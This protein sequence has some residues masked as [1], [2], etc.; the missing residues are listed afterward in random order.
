MSA[1]PRVA[2]HG[3]W[4][5]PISASALATG[6]VR[7]DQVRTC[8]GRIYW[9]EARPSEAGRCVVVCSDGDSTTDVTPPG[10]NA[11]SLVHEYGGG[12]YA[13]HESSVFFTN[14]EDQR[15]Y[16][17]DADTAPGNGQ[18]WGPPRP[19]T[20]EPPVAR[21]LRYA[22]FEPVP[23]GRGLYCV[24]EIHASA[25]E[26]VNE[27]VYLDLAGTREPRAV[28]GG[29]DFASFPRLNPA[30]DR[31]AW[32]TWDHPQMPFDGTDLWLGEVRADGSVDEV[33][34]VAGGPDESI[35]QPGFDP[36]GV[37]HFIS[38]RSGWWNLYS[39]DARGITPL[40]PMQAEFGRPQWALAMANYSFLPGGRIACVFGRDGTEH[41][42]VL[43]PG[44]ER[45]REIA[46]PF[47]SF[48]RIDS[49]SGSAIAITAASPEDSGG[50]VR[51][52]LDAGS[53]ELIRR[54]RSD[55]ID[56]AQVSRP[57]ALEFATTGG[58]VAHA[59]FY[60]PTNPAFRGPED[61]LPPLLVFSHGG[62][63]AA[64]SSALNFAVQYWTSRG[65]AVVDVNYRGSSGYGRAYR[66]SL[67]GQWGVADA[68]DC[69]AA[70]R[71]LASSG[72]VDPQ[73]LAIRG[74][75]AGGYTT[76]CALTFH[77]FF[78]AGASYYGIADA[79][80][81][82]ADTHKFES[83]YME[84]LIG[85]YPEAAALYRER[86]PIHFAERLSCPLLI[87]QGLEDA[88][89]PPA[90]AQVMVDALAAKKLPHAYLPFE[91]E[92]HGFRRAESIIRAAE[93]ELSFYGQIFGFTPADELP[94]LEI[95][96]LR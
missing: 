96:N 67:R 65:L 24:R 81:L 15:V 51:I 61:E 94:P 58:D 30:G 72:R 68:E 14:F 4:K 92:Q 60:P 87:L 49:L 93:A 8:A 47:S 18:R 77:D 38:D 83:R 23:D 55:A 1:S 35:Y 52:D 16:R 20:P 2:P 43:Q 12:A 54:S 79:E 75:S 13:V 64:S 31:L 46:T 9:I 56:A 50:V 69:I 90:Q 5:S 82:A 19:L 91:G 84:T 76:L 39:A 73:R 88:V 53:H 57:E 95:V 42:G 34:H 63:T 59:L 28:C 6:G 10:F 62:P 85:P 33:Q 36:N 32:T 71:A 26:A 74:G 78:A 37:L 45:L 29:H 70:A 3:S 17:Q 25:G 44:S 21:A 40:A 89:V 48:G 11:R 7:L 22:D 41:I 66:N 80:A 27:I 86:S